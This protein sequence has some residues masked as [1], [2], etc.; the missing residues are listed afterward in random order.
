MPKSHWR[1]L[2]LIDCRNALFQRLALNKFL[3]ITDNKLIIFAGNNTTERLI[4]AFMFIGLFWAKNVIKWRRA[5]FYIKINSFLI[6][7]K[8]IQYRSRHEEMPLVYVEA[9]TLIKLHGLCG[10]LRP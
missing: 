10:Q 1:D 3:L 8:M 9:K 5:V 7:D 6:Y 4:V 2:S